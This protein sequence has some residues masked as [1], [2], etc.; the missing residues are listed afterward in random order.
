MQESGSR[1]RSGRRNPPA[2]GRL[3]RG[4][5]KVERLQNCGI[6]TFESCEGGSDHAYPSASV[7]HLGRR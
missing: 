5:R 3:D 2:P 1:D 4:I 7:G 6:E